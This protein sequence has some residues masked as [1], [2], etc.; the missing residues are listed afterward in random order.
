MIDGK[1]YKVKLEGMRI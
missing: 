1:R